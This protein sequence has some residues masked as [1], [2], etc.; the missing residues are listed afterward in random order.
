MRSTFSG[1]NTVVRGLYS[2]QVS[3]DTVGHNISNANTDGYSR[4]TVNLSTTNPESLHISTG[5]A[6]I[7]T[8]VQT[9]SITRA[10]D[11]FMDKQ[12]WKESASLGYG[13][14]LES[15]LQKI[16]GVFKEPSDTGVQTVLNRFWTALQT[17]STNASDNGA[18]SAL[19]QRGVELINAV[20]HS[21]QQLKDMVSD[22]NSTLKIKVNDIN[23]INF[24]ISSLNKQIVN[25]EGGGIDHANDLRDRRDLL[26]DK[27]T[28]MIG[29]KISED[30]S[31]NYL[32]QAGGVSLVTATG[33]TKLEAKDMPGGDSDYGYELVN[34]YA[35]GKITPINFTNGE[36]KGLIDSR[37]N[38]NSGAK[39]Y[40]NQL[41]TIS[42]FLLQDF[43]EVH[44]DGYGLN[45]S[46]D[47]NFFGDNSKYYGTGSADI[48]GF[49]KNDWL[50]AL[51]VNKAL[52][53]TNGLALIA[54]KTR[55]GSILVTKDTAGAAGDMTV[56]GAYNGTSPA[57]FIVTIDAVNTVNKSKLSSGD[58]TYSGTTQGNFVVRIDSVD[59]AGSVTKASYSSN[60]GTTWN[61]AVYDS[62]SGQW[63]LKGDVKVAIAADTDNAQGNTYT[64]STIAGTPTEVSYTMNG[65]ASQKATLDPATETWILS[66]GVR[67]RMDANVANAA[68]GS[69]SFSISQGEA[70][71]DNAVLM[72]NK[73]KTDN[74]ALLGDVSLDS[75]YSSMIA[76]LGVQS[77]NA[78][79]LTENQKTLV[80]Q[81]SNWR[82]SV[83]GVN[84]DEEMTNM[85]RFQKGYNAA[86][87]VLTTMDE[88][89]DKLIN[90]TGVVG[91]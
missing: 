44:R 15:M 27:L 7:G 21:A 43:N 49:S 90:G 45:D 40:L 37:D 74:T 60:G 78:Q 58:L 89:L 53:D 56:D 87:R 41:S 70:S 33:Y 13:Q 54:A 8:G 32:I 59:G 63:T 82:Q 64:F 48:I 9:T 57:D 75:F 28:S 55:A 72:G 17:L 66:N 14:A 77:Q 22:I 3:L 62:G 91:R 81:I 18:R 79:R 24:E 52:F 20:Q 73:L 85:I 83:S 2:Q 16:E 47:V 23:Q 76:G 26:A 19:R 68:G 29:A 38:V 50:E 39:G 46:H 65:G 30:S 80:D 5:F 12:M 34:V 31:G 25:I 84:M 10:R 61:D 6:Q 71:G 67:V 88:M 11:V 51:E 35:P 86:A 69:Y 42:Q 4:Q 36:L 1:F